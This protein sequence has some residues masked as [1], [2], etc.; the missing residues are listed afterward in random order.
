MD[1]S[2][3]NIMLKQLVLKGNQ[4]LD[5]SIIRL[6]RY[7][8]YMII[9]LFGARC[10]QKGREESHRIFK[11]MELYYFLLGIIINEATVISHQVVGAFVHGPANDS[12]KT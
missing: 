11:Y 5:Y 6:H 10:S 3:I 1:S 2:V 12:I 9:W 7:R 4:I 8:Y